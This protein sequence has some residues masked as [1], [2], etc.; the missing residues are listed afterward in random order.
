MS[1][2]EELAKVSIE[3]RLDLATNN[4]SGATNAYSIA[5]KNALGEDKDQ[6]KFDVKV[7]FMIA[8]NA[9]VF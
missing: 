2:E 7:L 6:D 8:I 4:Q 9:D 1:R 3:A 5:L